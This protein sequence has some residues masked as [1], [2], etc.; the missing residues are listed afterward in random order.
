M[1]SILVIVF[2]FQLAVHLVN[3]IGA[4]AINDLV[5]LSRKI[6]FPLCVAPD[7]LTA[8]PPPVMDPLQQ[9]P[10]LPLLSHALAGRAQP[11]SRASEARDECY[12][13]AG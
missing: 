4:Q 11:G 1:P 13:L 2:V 6:A 8:T 10:Y 7:T 3:T 5:T 9:D 12:E